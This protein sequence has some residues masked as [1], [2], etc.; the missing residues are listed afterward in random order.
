MYRSLAAIVV[1]TAVIPIGAHAQAHSA[2]AVVRT[3]APSVLRN[4]DADLVAG[5]G[6]MV[7]ARGN[8]IRK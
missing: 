8:V 1:C 7:S 3:S 6:N 5:E 4:R 2:A